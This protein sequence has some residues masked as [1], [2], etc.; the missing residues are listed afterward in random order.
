MRG[1]V[2]ASW[3]Q[4]S[5]VRMIK[6]NEAVDWEKLGTLLFVSLTY[7]YCPST[8]AEAKRHLMAFKRRFE[9]RYGLAQASWKLEFQRRGVPH[10][11]LLMK[12]PE[13]ET[14]VS[15]REWIA[16]AWWEVCGKQ[17]DEHLTA[18]TEVDY[19]RSERSPGGYFAKYGTAKGKEYQNNAPEG[20]APGRWWGLWRIKPEWEQQNITPAEFW[21]LR[22]FCVRLKASRGGVGRGVARTFQGTWVRGDGLSRAIQWAREGEPVQVESP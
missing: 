19:W 8:G 7:H 18:G 16:Q 14:N 6:T 22:R 12:C 13:G 15:M 3:S 10:F 5:R 1:K 2:G 20:W 17:S 21:R 4:Q 9:R 11:H